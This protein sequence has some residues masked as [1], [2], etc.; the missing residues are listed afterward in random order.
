MRS[1]NSALNS[2]SRPVTEMTQE[3]KQEGNDE[4]ETLSEHLYPRRK[5]HKKSRTGC[6]N[7]RK[8]RVKCD[9]RRPQCTRC[10]KMEDLVCDYIF[11]ELPSTQQHHSSSSSSSS[12]EGS[13]GGD[14]PSPLQIGRLRPVAGKAMDAPQHSMMQLMVSIGRSLP[15][16]TEVFRFWNSTVPQLVHQ[17]EIIMHA[18]MTIATCVLSPDLSLTEVEERHLHH[19]S[20]ALG[21]LAQAVNS[22]TPKN[23]DVIL[24]TSNLLSLSA[25]TV[26]EHQQLLAGIN[27][28]MERARG[29]NYMVTK[30]VESRKQLQETKDDAAFFQ[31]TIQ[32][33]LRMSSE[34]QLQV[35]EERFCRS[36]CYYLNQLSMHLPLSQGAAAEFYFQMKKWLW[37][38]NPAFISRM[39]ESV[40]FLTCAKIIVYVL[41]RIENLCLRVLGMKYFLRA[42]EYAKDDGSPK[43]SLFD[44][45]RDPLKNQYGRETIEGTDWGKHLPAFKMEG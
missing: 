32:R 4:P 35:A 42:T 44:H 30:F 1:P 28:V 10:L 22:C 38:I 2:I 21:M 6:L 40:V 41:S 5:A 11:G 18:Y 31:I 14:A 25:Q 45:T 7:C 33:I 9:E 24:M 37:Y 29:G 27:L 8:R 12:R 17:H 19:R 36:F 15:H 20:A 34:A 39:R 43:F 26:E 23:V 3:T 16:Q 13:A